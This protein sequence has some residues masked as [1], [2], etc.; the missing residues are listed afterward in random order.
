[1]ILSIPMIDEYI[2][3]LVSLDLDVFPS[4]NHEN[5]CQILIVSYNFVT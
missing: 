1:M 5:H 3:Q 4:E 2:G